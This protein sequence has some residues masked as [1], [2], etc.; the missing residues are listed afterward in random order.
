MGEIYVSTDV[1]ADGP[2]PGPH[3]MLSVGSAAFTADKQLVGT[4]EV[5]LETLDGASPHPQTM[6]W[7]EGF[8]DAWAHCRTNQEPVVHA[9]E[10]Y[11][12]WLDGLP[13][14]P[15]FV[16][17]PAGFDFT[18][19]RYYL[20][21]FAGRCPFGFAALDV[22]SFAMAILGTEFRK[23]AKRFMPRDWFDQK[24]HSHRALEDAIEQGQLFCNMLAA[25]DAALRLRGDGSVG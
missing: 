11:C 25:R 3:S 23:T 12:V 7:W 10:K 5:N 4:F 14:V 1:E 24:Q 22:K 21:R 9:M 15:V 13:G 2:I 20:E 17:Y 8:P 6:K 18:F 16:G 19:V